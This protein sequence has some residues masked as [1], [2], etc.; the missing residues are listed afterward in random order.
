MSLWLSVYRAFRP[1]D[2]LC[3]SSILVSLEPPAISKRAPLSLTAKISIHRERMS[4]SFVVVLTNHLA[5]NACACCSLGHE[6]VANPSAIGLKRQARTTSRSP[7][8]TLQSHE[9]VGKPPHGSD[10]E[11]M[12]NQND[13]SPLFNLHGDPST[14]TG[15]WG[16]PYGGCGREPAGPAFSPLSGDLQTL[17]SLA[18]ARVPILTLYIHVY[19]IYR[20]PLYSFIYPTPGY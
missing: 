15:V 8:H 4:Q 1:L 17:S 10:T 18:R 19:Y 20:I 7:L 6:S 5:T 9:H 3:C 12:Q 14:R 16:S 13:K 11:F 2:P